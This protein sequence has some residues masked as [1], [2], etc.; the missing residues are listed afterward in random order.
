MNS[1]ELLIHEHDNILQM[2][3]VAHNASLRVLAG[4]T[5]DVSDFRKM[6]GFI[7]NYADKTHHGKEEEF[8]FKEMVEHLGGIGDNLIRHGMLVE[9]SLGRLYVSELDDALTA[10]EAAPSAES[11]LAILVSAGS[12]VNLLRRHI[13]RENGVVFSFGQNNLPAEAMERVEA[14]TTAFE[15]DPENAAEREKQ[16]AIL[17]ELKQKYA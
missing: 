8:L 16:L 15:N 12:Y 11:R 1:V 4:E 5:P 3:D 2:L 13:D 9:H 10:Y 7:R 14:Q 17:D 6:I